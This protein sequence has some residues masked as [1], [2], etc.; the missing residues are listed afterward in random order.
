M[1]SRTRR[2]ARFVPAVESLEDRCTP[3]ISNSLGFDGMTL[4]VQSLRLA[5]TTDQYTVVVQ[6]SGSQVSQLYADVATGKTVPTATVTLRDGHLVYTFGYVKATSFQFLQGAT[7]PA[8]QVVFHYQK[9][10]V[11]YK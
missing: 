7:G 9:V 5:P 3:S 1:L 11:V 8:E 4:P 2:S 6:A 10:A